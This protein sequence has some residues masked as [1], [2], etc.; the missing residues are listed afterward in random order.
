MDRHHT[1]EILDPDFDDPSLSDE[2][3]D[4]IIK[5]ICEGTRQIWEEP[6]YFRPFFETPRFDLARMDNWL[7]KDETS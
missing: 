7:G 5:W 2:E 4:L 6:E 1:A 3:S